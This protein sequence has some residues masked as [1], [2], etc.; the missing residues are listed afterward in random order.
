VPSVR[1]AGVR[2]LTYTRQCH[3]TGIRRFNVARRYFF[4]KSDSALHQVRFK[5]HGWVAFPGPA[6]VSVV[7]G[8]I[9]FYSTDLRAIDALLLFILSSVSPPVGYTAIELRANNPTRAVELVREAE[10]YQ[11]AHD[12]PLIP[13]YIS[14]EAYL[15]AKQGSAAALERY[16]VTVLSPS[17]LRIALPY[18]A[19]RA[20]RATRGIVPSAR[21]SLPLC[22]ATCRH[23]AARH[24]RSG[25][26]R[27]CGGTRPTHPC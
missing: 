25:G 27:R 19:V 7:R 3:P 1:L 11:W 23:F 24:R 15:A 20:R 22:L 5:T 17:V 13:V 12:Y 16:M 8:D 4:W 18:P 26:R 10:P 6:I 14:G 2:T 21:E 9:A